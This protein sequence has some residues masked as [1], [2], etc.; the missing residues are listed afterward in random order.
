MKTLISAIFVQRPAENLDW[1]IYILFF[2]VL[3]MALNRI[4]FSNNFKA[5]A[6]IERFVEVNDNQGIFSLSLQLVFAA[7]L[8]ALLVPYIIPDYDFIFYTP[9]LK[10]LAVAVIVL[11]FFVLRSLFGSLGLFAFKIPSDQHLNFRSSS[12]YRA[13]SVMVL[14]IAVTLYYFSGLNRLAI[15]IVSIIILLIIR[16]LHIIYKYRNQPEQQTKIWYYNILYLCA[17]EILPLLVLFK[18]LTVR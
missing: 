16:M 3:L 15:F 6:S 4:L 2:S 17:L 8:G 12:Y 18:F 1:V 13:Y 9:V 7:L 10:V 14:W 5:L 11:L